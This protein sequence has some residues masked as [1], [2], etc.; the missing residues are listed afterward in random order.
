MSCTADMAD[1][2]VL[3]AEGKL[4]RLSPFFVPKTLVN[5]AAGAVS[6]AHGLQGPNHAVATACATGA[7]A[8][9]DAFSMIRRGDADVMLAGGTESCVDAIALAGFGR[10][11][12]LSTRYNGDP[13]AASRPFDR[14]RDGFV[15]GEGAG[16]V[17]LEELQHALDRGAAIYGEVRGY[18]LS[19]DAHHITQPPP[20]GIGAQLAMRGA[21]RQAGLRPRDICYINAHATSTPQGDDIEQRAIAAVFG[22]AATSASPPGGGPPLAVSST[23]GATGH[24]LGAAG[25]VEAIFSLLALRHGVAPATANLADPDP[26]LLANLVAGQPCA[27]APGPRAVLSNSFGFGGT[28]AALVFCTAPGREG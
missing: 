14:H 6:I 10:L 9:G 26:P 25:A 1:A 8:I 22:E 20:D 17:V 19:G 2:G 18:G 23:K 16:V 3:V 27:L 21:L 4:R 24:L 13:A 12:A 11:K 15:M 28:N 7:H 5:M